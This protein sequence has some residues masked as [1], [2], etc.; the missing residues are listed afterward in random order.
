MHY[1]CN[2][3]ELQQLLENE[4]VGKQI[5][6]EY[7]NTV[8]NCC[9]N[10]EATLHGISYFLTQIIEKKM[11][12]EE[13]CGDLI[14]AFYSVEDQMDFVVQ[15]FDEAFIDYLVRNTRDKNLSLEDEV[16]QVIGFMCEYKY[17]RTVRC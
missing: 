5:E 9:Q 11:K 6:S 2:K 10:W 13:D 16:I 7:L 12:N 1:C 17:D 3:S 4:C 8:V 15:E 14:N